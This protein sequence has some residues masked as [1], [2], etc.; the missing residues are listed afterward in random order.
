MCDGR[1]AEFGHING[2]GARGRH[3]GHHEGAISRARGGG[4]V[5]VIDEIDICGGGKCTETGDDDTMVCVGD[6]VEPR[7]RCEESGYVTELNGAGG[8]EVTLP[9]AGER[10]G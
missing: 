8:V 1:S 5:V 10:P 2:D 4:I 3:V 7:T 9:A 6:E